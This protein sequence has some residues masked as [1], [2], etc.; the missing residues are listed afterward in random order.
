MGLSCGPVVSAPGGPYRAIEPKLS[1][2]RPRAPRR[3]PGSVRRS[4]RIADV[5]LGVFLSGGVDSPLVTPA[6]RRQAGAGLKG[7]TIGNPGWAQDESA[8]AR[9]YAGELDLVHR[10][11]SVT[12]EEALAAVPE[13]ITAQH[14]PFADISIIP[15]LLV[16]RFARA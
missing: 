16:S 12:G 11:H 15:T 13:V 2:S 4:Q 8:A 9:A 14:E 10:L 3:D 5:P 6:A 7:F 1:G